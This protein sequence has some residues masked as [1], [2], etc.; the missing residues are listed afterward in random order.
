[1]RTV[2]PGGAAARVSSLLWK[3]NL[4]TPTMFAYFSRYGARS[5]RGPNRRCEIVYEPD[6]FES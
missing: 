2:G 3:S 6:F 5:G 1:M 4:W